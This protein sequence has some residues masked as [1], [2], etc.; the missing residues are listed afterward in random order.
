[1]HIT[2]FL[3]TLLRLANEFGVAVVITNQVVA[4][5]DCAAMFSGDPKEPIGGR[6]ETRVCKIC[7]RPCLPEAETM[8]PISP[9]GIGDAKDQEVASLL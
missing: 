4:Q 1:M 6:G 9:D 8:Y 3:R 5:V 2:R 7:G